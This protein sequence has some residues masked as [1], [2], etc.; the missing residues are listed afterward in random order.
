MSAARKSIEKK[1]K[2]KRGGRR[3]GAGRKPGVGN[4]DLRPLRQRIQSL[5]DDN[6]ER[7]RRNVAKLGPT[8][9]A[10]FFLR[11]YEYVIP[12][13]RRTS[14]E[15]ELKS[16][17]PLLAQALFLFDSLSDAEQLEVYEMVEE[18]R[19]QKHEPDRQVSTN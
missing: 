19:K 11:L 18:L 4:K 13:L 5:I 15:V 2:S 16:S 10:D 9:H 14:L 1:Q 6:D 7:L 3:E 12:R 17:K 8:A